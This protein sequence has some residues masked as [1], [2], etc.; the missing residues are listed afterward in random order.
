MKN[1]EASDL[2]NSAII[3]AW[4]KSG[5]RTKLIAAALARELANANPGD[6]V[7]SSM[8]IAARFGTSSTMAANARY[9]LI[10]QGII[11]KVGCHYYVA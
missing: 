10:S 7:E 4:V 11:R 2:V 5:S 9:H 1:A 3:T 8:K 6:R